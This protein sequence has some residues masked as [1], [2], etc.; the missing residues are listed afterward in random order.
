MIEIKDVTFSYKGCLALKN[1]NLT[2]NEG[3]SIALIGPNGSGKST[4]LKL[5]NGILFPDKGEFLF[6]GQLINEHYFAKS[7]NSKLFHKNIGFVFQNSDSQ[8][9]CS[10][11]YEEIAFGPRQMGMSENEINERVKD[12]LE[13]LNIENIKHREPYHLSGGEKRKVAIASVLALNPEVLVLDE[14]MNG[15]DPKGKNFLKELII[16]LNLSGKT[17][18]CSTHD[19]QYVEGMFKRAIVFSENHKIIRDD[20]YSNVLSDKAFLMENN[21]I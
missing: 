8:L 12:C 15:I 7:I 5:I 3:E 21:I 19:F 14:P 1:I 11:V 2:I 6:Q 9:F 17:I 18:I 20:V 13:L 16:K 10:N 4:L